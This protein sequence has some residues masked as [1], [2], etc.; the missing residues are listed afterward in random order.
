MDQ[1]LDESM[2]SYNWVSGLLVT[3]HYD[4]GFKILMSVYLSPIPNLL[5]L[6][7]IDKRTYTYSAH[8]TSIVAMINC[9]VQLVERGQT[10]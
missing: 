4:A 2:S 9:H 5:I 8:N 3:R 10:L 6:F 7:T 1:S